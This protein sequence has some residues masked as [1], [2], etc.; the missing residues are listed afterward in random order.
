MDDPPPPSRL[1]TCGSAN[2][3]TYHREPG[4]FLDAPSAGPLPNVALSLLL[5]DCGM[6]SYTVILSCPSCSSF[7]KDDDLQCCISPSPY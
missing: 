3:L 4:A 2:I 6:Y 1:S 7:L 5:A